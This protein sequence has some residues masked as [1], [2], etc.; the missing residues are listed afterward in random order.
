VAKEIER[1]F[2][3]RGDAWRDA[4]SRRRQLRQGYLASSPRTSV[5]V[6]IGGSDAWLNI[7]Q[8]GLE[9]ERHEYE[10]PIP[11]L[12]A[13]ELLAAV[14]PNGVLEKTR[15]WVAHAG[16]EWEI[17]EF[18]GANEG[19]IVAEV[20]LERIDQPIEFPEWIGAEVTHLERYYNVRLVRR[21]YREWTSEERRQ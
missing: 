20:E 13:D 10:Y 12:D 1:K 5:R 6:R 14:G 15:H 21:P 7:K 11:L 19:L 3:L 17:D 4:V 18:H 9:P 16:L 2:L 8:G